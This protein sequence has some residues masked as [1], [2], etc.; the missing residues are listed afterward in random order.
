MPEGM[1]IASQKF[2]SAQKPRLNKNREIIHLPNCLGAFAFN[3]SEIIFQGQ[4]NG[5]VFGAPG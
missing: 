3:K 5:F 2:K 1:K 4:N